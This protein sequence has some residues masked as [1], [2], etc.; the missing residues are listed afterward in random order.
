MLLV[1]A[2]ELAQAKKNYF[3]DEITNIVEVK[4][5]TGEFE[6]AIEHH[7]IVEFY[8]PYCVRR[9]FLSLEN[10]KARSHH[11]FFFHG[12]RVTALNSRAN[13]GTLFNKYREST[14]V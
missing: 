8:N 12:H 10:A 11:C 2:P 5:S 13:T 6:T 1:T 3:Y 14:L 4:G 7:R 9:G